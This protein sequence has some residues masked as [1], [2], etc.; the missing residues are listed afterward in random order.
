[1]HHDFFTR[2][3][4]YRLLC[5]PEQIPDYCLIIHR[6]SKAGFRRWSRF[7]VF[8]SISFQLISASCR[9]AGHPNAGRS[10][11]RVGGRRRGSSDVTDAAWPQGC[12]S[13]QY[14]HA[15]KA[16]EATVTVSFKRAVDMAKTAE[17]LVVGTISRLRPFVSATMAATAKPATTCDFPGEDRLPLQ[18]RSLTCSSSIRP[19][20][21]SNDTSY[22]VYKRRLIF[23]NS[24][25]KE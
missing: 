19:P 2:A 9:D 16:P 24:P 18:S 15:A 3:R 13:A 17:K 8:P 5:K 10:F 25:A 14:G 1:M 7:V 12:L 22:P 6:V 11:G 20:P 23:A 21:R 4:Y